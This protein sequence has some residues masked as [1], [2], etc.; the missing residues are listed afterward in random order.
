MANNN[1]Q[2]T[3]RILSSNIV[4]LVPICSNVLIY[5]MCSTHPAGISKLHR[6]TCVLCS[7]S[8]R[9]MDTVTQHAHT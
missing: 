7:I 4:E 9:H 2:Y 1:K 6:R 8:P 3:R 5:V